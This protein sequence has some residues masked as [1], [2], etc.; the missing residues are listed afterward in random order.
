M[1]EKRPHL[2][3][4]PLCQSKGL[5][6]QGT[7]KSIRDDLENIDEYVRDS[8]NPPWA[9]SHLVRAIAQGLA[10]RDTKAS[11]ALAEIAN[12]LGLAI[13]HPFENVMRGVEIPTAC[14]REVYWTPGSPV[15]EHWRAYFKLTPEE[16]LARWGHATPTTEKT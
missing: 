8:G 7:D 16:A 10:G 4:H 15:W 12:Y 3:P 6:F 13:P 5:K 1:S 9:A 2:I 14:H 11:R